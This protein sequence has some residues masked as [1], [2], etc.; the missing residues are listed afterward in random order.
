MRA[1]TTLLAELIDAD[2]RLDPERWQTAH[3]DGS[4][5]AL[6]GCRGLVVPNPDE[7]AVT[8]H[9]GVAWYAMRCTACGHET[10]VTGARKMP[11]VPRTSLALL[12]AHAALERRKLA[13][14]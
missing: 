7:P 1:A 4:P 14:A 13:D 12:E 10:E 5:V 8:V 9:F 11:T 2:G 6:C 3:T